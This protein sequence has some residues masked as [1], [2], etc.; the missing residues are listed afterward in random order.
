[1]DA[2]PLGWYLIRRWTAPFTTVVAIENANAPM[3]SP[4]RLEV[5]SERSTVSDPEQHFMGDN[6]SEVE[7]GDGEPSESF[8][9]RSACFQ[10]DDAFQLID[11]AWRIPSSAPVYLVLSGMFISAPL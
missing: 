6:D 8:R 10:A 5:E 11:E 7:D 9:P 4:P 2:F 3:P 1:M